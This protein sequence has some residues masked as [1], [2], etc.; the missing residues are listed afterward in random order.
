VRGTVLHPEAQW[1]AISRDSYDFV[2]DEG[3][4]S[5]QMPMTGSLDPLT[6]PL[7]A[8]HLAAHTTTPQTCHFAL[9]NGYGSVPKSWDQHPQFRL[10]MRGYWLFTPAPIDTVVEHSVEFEVAGLAEQAAT[11]EGISTLAMV[12]QS[13]RQR[14][15][16]ELVRMRRESGDLRSPSWW[17][18][19]DHAWAVLSETDY[20]STLVAAS[21]DLMNALLADP[22]IECLRVNP[23]DSLLASADTINDHWPP[24]TLRLNKPASPPP[25]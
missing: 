6:L 1:H 24:G 9:W 19:E 20:D 25:D 4:L 17:W 13:D 16:L 2:N 10:P 18:P 15:S 14:G 22:D 8:R 11:P 12:G 23:S 3:T 21:I 7:L 5:S